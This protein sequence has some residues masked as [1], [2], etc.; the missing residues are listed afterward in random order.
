MQRF[1][2]HACTLR[3]QLLPRCG[4]AA[5]YQLVDNLHVWAPPG[6]GAGRRERGRRRRRPGKQILHPRWSLYV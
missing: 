6:P 3:H 1:P 5:G 2:L 4:S